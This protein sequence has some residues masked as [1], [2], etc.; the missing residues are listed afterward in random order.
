MYDGI[1]IGYYW[2]H[3]RCKVDITVNMSSGIIIAYMWFSEQLYQVTCHH[4]YVSNDQYICLMRL[5]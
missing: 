2:T 5:Q 1:I 3:I 4:W